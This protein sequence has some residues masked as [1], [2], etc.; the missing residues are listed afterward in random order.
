MSTPRLLCNLHTM[1]LVKA[2]PGGL[3]DR[4]CKKMALC[5][6]PQI[7]YVPEK[8][9]V[10]AAV[11]AFKDNHLK[12]LINKDTELQ[13]S[14]WHSGTCETFL[15]HV[16]SGQEAIQKKGHFKSYKDSSESCAEQHDKI[17]QLKASYWNWMKLLVKLELLKSPATIPRNM[18]NPACPHN[19]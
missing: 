4:K 1:S 17:K 13:V 15:I 14:I 8:D 9:S 11:S 3:K 19:G 6:C 7:P 16:G 2:A 5:K 10:Q 12:T 18:L